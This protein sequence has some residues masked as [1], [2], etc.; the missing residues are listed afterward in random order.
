MRFSAFFLLG[1]WLSSCAEPDVKSTQ[2]HYTDIKGFV[3]SE[4]NRL[5]KSNIRVNKTVVQNGISESLSNIAVNWKNELALFSESDINKS[6]WKD[7]YKVIE[8]KESTEYHALDSNLRTKLITIRYNKNKETVYL[9]IKNQ[10]NNS[11]YKTNETLTYIPDSAY[12]VIKDQ[13][14]LFLGKNRYEIKGNLIH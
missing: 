14:V 2:K 6:A 10:T 7:S 9:E 8:K 5:S 12:T 3:E 1:L 11:L 13:K 4:V